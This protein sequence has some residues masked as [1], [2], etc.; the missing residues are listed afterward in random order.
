MKSSTYKVHRTNITLG[1]LL[2]IVIGIA[3][4]TTGCKKL[5]EVDAPVTSVN[6][7]NVY[8]NDATATAVLTGIYTKISDY[9]YDLTLVDNISG[10]SL[11]PAL[12]ADELTLYNLSNTILLLYYRNDL[13]SLIASGGV[14]W[15]SIYPTI[16]VANSA[17]E[18]LNNSTGLTPAVKQQLLGEA[19]FMRAFCYFYLVN[20]YGDVPLATSSDYKIN[21]LLTRTSKAQVYQQIIQDLKDAQGSLSSG[22][23]AADGVTSTPERVRPTKWTATALLARVYLYTGDYP[24][25]E[26]QATAVINNSST[27]SLTDLNDAFLMNSTEAI[28]QL[29][30]V[31]SGE[32]S[33]T[34]EG[35]LFI[36]PSTGLDAS[37]YPVY[38]SANVI[39]SFEAG[40][41]RKTNWVN[42]VTVGGTTYYYPYKY[43]I[44]KVN[45]GTQQYIMVMRLGEQYLI[46][47]EARA[48]QNNTNGAQTDLNTIRTRAGLP[49]TTA[50]DNA[51]LL[52]AIMH[53]RQVELFTEWGHR[54]FDLKR[55]NTID[56][57]M[58]TVAVQK[59]G[60]WS[61]YKALY[62]IPQ[63]EINLDQGLV[64]N[65]GY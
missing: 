27:Y 21:S 33:N 56:A 46:R 59:G 44:G 7:A 19:K 47:A 51:S 5:V 14:F 60:T 23:V 45:T 52:A 28:W 37:S 4:S 39:N 24:N 48:R 1:I 43:K 58:N 53:E 3:F 34:G 26:V 61:S 35:A 62:P 41:L 36:L 20:L 40:D 25:A 17:I 54:W 42:N 2:P 38:L 55:T 12:S 18:G 31:R 8:T 15:K 16:F 22:Y 63:T 32:Q 65:S 6:A 29:Q 13:T 49:N 11:F 9:N 64:Q 50:N 30:P 57:V 10:L